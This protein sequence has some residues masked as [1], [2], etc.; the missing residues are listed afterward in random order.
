MSIER[1][2]GLAIF[3]GKILFTFVNG[4]LA[5]CK[6]ASVYNDIM[7]DLQLGSLGDLSFDVSEVTEGGDVPSDFVSNSAIMALCH[8]LF[9]KHLCLSLC[10]I[11]SRKTKCCR[12]PYSSS[13]KRCQCH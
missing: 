11:D 3:Y 5:G 10:Q 1:E 8:H 12:M 13:A 9:Y 6:E 2:E 4:A 7:G